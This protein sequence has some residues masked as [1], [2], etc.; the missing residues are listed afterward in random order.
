MP[1]DAVG[2]D[3]PMPG[4][5]EAAANAQMASLTPPVA[6][7][8][9]NGVLVQLGGEEYDVPCAIATELCRLRDAVRGAAVIV[10]VAKEDRDEA[11]KVLSALLRNAHDS[12]DFA[13][14]LIERYRLPSQPRER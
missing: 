9:D 6:P 11:I 2:Y 13:Q 8:G 10:S 12:R 5:L 3:E 7:G 4:V 1:R 14:R